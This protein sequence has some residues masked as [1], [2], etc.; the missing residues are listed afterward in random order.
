MDPKLNFLFA[1]LGG[2]FIISVAM[3]LRSCGTPAIPDYFDRTLTLP[4]AIEQAAR[5]DRPVLALFTADWCPPCH[6]L[7]KGALASDAVRAWIADHAV[8][9]YVDISKARSGDLDQQVLSTRYRVQE[10]PTLLLLRDGQE[11]S[12]ITGNIPRRDLMKWLRQFSTDAGR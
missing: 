9:A 8:P 6:D 11:L 7:K 4:A 3:S 1:L 10:L 2:I 12:R 5:D